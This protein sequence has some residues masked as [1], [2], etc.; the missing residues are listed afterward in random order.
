MGGL[1]ARAASARARN[2][3][4]LRRLKRKPP[5]DLDDAFGALH[6]EAFAHIDC[7]T[8]ANCCKTTSPRILPKDVARLAKFLG[9]KP[10]AFTD[11]YLHED[12]DGDLVLNDTPCPFLG[13][14][15]YCTVYEARP[16]ACR[17]FPHTDERKMHTHT[18]ITLENVAVCPAVAGIVERLHDRYG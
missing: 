14:D 9:T 5:R 8:C 3:A 12:D 7:L 16:T 10:G 18:Q 1:A 2:R 4:L 15:N 13:K 11:Q 17:G 6:A